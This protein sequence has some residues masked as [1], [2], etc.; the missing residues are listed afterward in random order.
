VND[1]RTTTGAEPTSAAP[2]DE[3][4]A[5]I[6]R[7]IRLSVNF[8]AP[9]HARD[10]AIAYLT[11]LDDLLEHLTAHPQEKWV[12]YYGR[13]RIGFGTDYLELFRECA[14]KY[15]DGLFQIRGIDGADKCPED[16]VI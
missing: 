8:D 2:T 5:E 11:E 10:A 16:T 12:A 15:P 6:N 9:P 7:R 14:A 4:A 13:Q 1:P 3:K